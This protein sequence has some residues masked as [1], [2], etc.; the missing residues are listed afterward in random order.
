MQR[1][2]RQSVQR[3]LLSTSFSVQRGLLAWLFTLLCVAAGGGAL[4]GTDD[5]AK[6]QYL[7]TAGLL[8]EV[9]GEAILTDPYFSN[10]PLSALILLR[11]LEP[12]MSA[13]DRFLPDLGN[14]RGLLIGH[15]HYDHLM[16]VPA[17]VPKLPDSTRVIGSKTSLNQI[18][19][20]LP[21]Y[22][23]IEAKTAATSD[24]SSLPWIELT[25]Q[26]RVLPIRSG[27]SRHIAGFTFANAEVPEPLAA[28]PA[29]V[30]DWQGGTALN[31]VIEWHQNGRVYFRVLFCSSAAE[32]PLGIPPA[33]Y[34][35][36]SK[37]FDVIF[38]PVAK[39]Q[40]VKGFPDA[41]L[42]QVNAR[43]LVLIHWEAFWKPYVPGR[44]QAI[45]ESEVAQMRARLSALAPRARI[46]QP[47][48]LETLTIPLE[49][50]L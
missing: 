19:S 27:H 38:L 10:S 21:A 18:A 44:E 22:R 25:A 3:R 7:G 29:D 14:V 37:A 39:F 20:R 49:V 40:S 15:G 28:L 8:L 13:I 1:L 35:K 26:L 36:T 48:R 4:A 12:D 46:Y 17:V 31:Y 45:S 42:G 32:A 16:D 47:A 50:E 33:S 6:I 23:R 34:L 43:H 9:D 41:L 24:K 2:K 30:L 5:G 11:D